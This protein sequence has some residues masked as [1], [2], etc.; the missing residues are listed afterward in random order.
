MTIRLQKKIFGLLL[1]VIIRNKFRLLAVNTIHSRGF[2]YCPDSNSGKETKY[3]TDRRSSEV[4]LQG[5]VLFPHRGDVVQSL[6]ERKQPIAKLIEGHEMAQL[7][8]CP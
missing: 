1:N 5:V 2:F 6:T 4:K 8:S 3:G 7:I